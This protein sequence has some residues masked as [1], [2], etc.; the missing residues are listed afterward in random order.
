MIIKGINT[1]KEGLFSGVGLSFIGVLY[2]IVTRVVS[3]KKHPGRGQPTPIGHA[4]TISTD[5]VA[6]P[7]P[8]KVVSNLSAESIRESIRAAP[9]LQ[10]QELA[11]HYIGIRVK[12]ETRLSAA[13]Q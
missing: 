12:W 10:R 3:H 6:Q 13:T 2:L 8:P 4:V 11:R 9:P 5:H 1:N 7:Y